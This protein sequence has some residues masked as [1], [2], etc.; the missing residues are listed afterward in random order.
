MDSKNAWFDFWENGKMVACCPCAEVFG[1]DERAQAAFWRIQD[2]M[3][4]AV[5]VRVE[6]GEK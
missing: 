2:E 5:M 1:M 4:R 6:E 3:D